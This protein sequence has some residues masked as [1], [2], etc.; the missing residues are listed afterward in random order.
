MKKFSTVCIIFKLLCASS[1]LAS[2]AL[3]SFMEALRNASVIRVL[4][5]A[6]RFSY[7][8]HCIRSQSPSEALRNASVFC[9][10]LQQMLSDSRCRFLRLHFASRFHCYRRFSFH[11]QCRTQT[12]LMSVPGLKALMIVM[13]MLKY[14]R[15]GRHWQ[16]RWRKTG[17]RYLR[18]GAPG[19]KQALRTHV[20]ALT[21]LKCN[22]AINCSNEALI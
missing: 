17:A 2:L 4:Y 20:L 11:C 1:C 12:A 15:T 14:W 5:T 9:L 7:H 21:A 3:H 22:T 16:L 8:W 13:R 19:N 18:R 6:P 10:R